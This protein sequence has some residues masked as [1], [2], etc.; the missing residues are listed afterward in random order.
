MASR[1]RPPM[2]NAMSWW[3]PR[4]HPRCRRLGK[5][6][7]GP[8]PF[9][10]RVLPLKISSD[11]FGPIKR[12]SGRGIDLSF[13]RVATIHSVASVDT[14]LRGSTDQ[15]PNWT[16]SRF[17]NRIAPDGIRGTAD[18]IRNNGFRGAQTSPR[19]H[20][21]LSHSRHKRCTSS[22]AAGRSFTNSTLN[23]A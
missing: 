10:A 3:Q 14:L 18:P 11:P 23:P 7:S 12:S 5:A 19:I 4:L 13:V 6:C 17:I 9:R 15:S 16:N 22:P 2:P 20:S 8:W 21:A 1:P